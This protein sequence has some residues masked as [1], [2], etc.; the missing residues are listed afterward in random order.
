LKTLILH[1]VFLSLTIATAHAAQTDP[2]PVKPI[3]LVVPYPPGGGVDIVGR[4]IAQRLVEGLRQTV[5]VDNRAGAGGTLGAELVQRATADGYNLMIISTSYAVNANLYRIAYDPVE[6]ISPVGLIGTAPFVL[7]VNPS[8]PATSVKMLLA[9]AKKNPGKLNYGSTG[10]GAITH[11]ATELLDLMA[12]IRMTHIPYKGAGPALT[13]LLGGQLDVLLG[14]TLSTLPHVRTGKLRA[15][16]VTTARRSP[17]MP[18]TP[19]V[20]ESGVPGYDC[21]LWYAIL[22]PP[23]LPEA[24]SSRLNEELGR[25]LSS[26]EMKDRLAQEGMLPSPLGRAELRV[27]LKDEIGKW[28]RV[29]KAVGVKLE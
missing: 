17:V 8:V 29:V 3:R 25:V 18:D 23:N 28:G 13:D 11:L 19:T 6:Q 12:G 7:A 4:H 20:A 16:A 27:F 26:D 21:A 1:A 10:Q 24:V 9:L 22:G 2:Y 5:V 15:L 14:S